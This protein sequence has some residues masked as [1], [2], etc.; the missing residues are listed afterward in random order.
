MDPVFVDIIVAI[1]AFF[2]LL[3]KLT[4]RYFSKSK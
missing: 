4:I 1:I 3:G 2:A